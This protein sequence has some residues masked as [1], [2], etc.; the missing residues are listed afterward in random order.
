[1]EYV[2]TVKLRDGQ[3]QW[4]KE[5]EIPYD[6]TSFTVLYES[7]AMRKYIF[8]SEQDAVMFSMKWS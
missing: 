5:N 2:V 4:L 1:M 8:A 6:I 7:G 3:L